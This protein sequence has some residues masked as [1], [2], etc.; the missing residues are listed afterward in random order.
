MKNIIVFFLFFVALNAFSQNKI[1]RSAIWDNSELFQ[2][3][4][5]DKYT[6]YNFSSLWNTTE[7]NAVYGVIGDNYQRIFIKFTSVKRN[8]KDKTEYTVHGKSSVKSNICDFTGT[9][10]IIKIQELKKPKFGVDDE[11]KNAGI[12]SQGLLT[13]SYKFIENKKQKNTGEFQGKLQ[14][15]FYIDQHNL[16]KYNDI[17][18]YRDNYFNNAF[19]GI[20]KSNTTGK[21]KI[22]NWGDYRVPNVNCDFDSGAGELS[23]SQKYL[24]N[25]WNV[26]PKQNW[27]K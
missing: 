7:N 10:T 15:I 20:W 18:S 12:K 21:D 25:G 17:E 4:K 27:W 1:C 3:N 23:I 5:V 9:I 19:V 22:C 11:Y 14:T 2:I 16:V 8:E 24:K 26:K 6:N 13:A